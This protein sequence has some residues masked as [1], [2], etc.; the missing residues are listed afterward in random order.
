MKLTPISSFYKIFHVETKDVLYYYD[1]STK[2]RTIYKHI[3]DPKSVCLRGIVVKSELRMI[4]SELMLFIR[5][6]YEGDE[7]EHFLSLEKVETKNLPLDMHN[8][9]D[10]HEME[11]KRSKEE[12]YDNLTLK[13]VY[14]KLVK[15]DER[16][17]KMGPNY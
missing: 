16:L 8:A 7:C 6:Y 1:A 2:S 12:F 14:K 15:I 9:I 10:T 3:L 11:Y 13:D 5:G 17:K 4:A